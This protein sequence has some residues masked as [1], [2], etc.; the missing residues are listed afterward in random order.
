MDPAAD[1]FAPPAAGWTPVS[2][3][4]ATARRVTLLLS[5]LLVVAGG[6]ILVL[7]PLSIM[8]VA[9]YAV[10]AQKRLPNLLSLLM[11]RLTS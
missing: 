10:L 2:P 3:R 1:A 9:A 11:M 4:L 7:S 8:W 6:V 5:Y